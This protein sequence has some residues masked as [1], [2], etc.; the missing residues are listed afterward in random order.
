[1]KKFVFASVFLTVLTAVITLSNSSAF[2]QNTSD[3]DSVETKK[4]IYVEMI[5]ESIK[6]KEEMPADS[7]FK[8]IQI[9]KSV[10]A[11]RLVMIMDKGFSKALGVSCEHC[12]N[13][14][15]FASNEKNEKQIT[16]KMMEMSGQIREM[17]S[18]IK[19]IESKEATINCTTCHRGEIVPATKLK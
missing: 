15:N 11:G 4:K 7:V 18:N 14:E 8:D 19:E 16:R 2:N 5:N 3:S 6:G 1:M 17:I 9:M 10:P 12:H 13:T